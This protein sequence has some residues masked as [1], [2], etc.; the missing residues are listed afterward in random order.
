MSMR[1]VSV[2]VKSR[3]IVSSFNT[4]LWN[5]VLFMRVAQETTLA[6]KP[7]FLWQQ[8]C[9][10]YFRIFLPTQASSRP[11]RI[12]RRSRNRWSD[13]CTYQLIRGIFHASPNVLSTGVEWRGRF[14]RPPVQLAAMTCMKMR[15]SLRTVVIGCTHA[16][17]S[18]HMCRPI[19]TP[20][21]TLY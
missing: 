13:E 6:F 4:A 10:K 5:S 2:A 9:S 14:V 1:K 21:R 7:G 12:C 8:T 11:C 15:E 19:G 3:E 16:L 17:Q 20:C 18:L